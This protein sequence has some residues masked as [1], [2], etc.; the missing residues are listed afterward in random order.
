MPKFRFQ[1]DGVLRQRKLVEEQ[2]QREFGAVQAELVALQAQLREMDDSVQSTVGDLR[3]N[4]LVGR[5]DLSFLTAHRRYMLAMQRKAVALA[6][7]IAAAQVKVDEARAALL[8]AAMQ[9]KVIEKLRERRRA[10]WALE[11]E[12]KDMALLDEI[13]T[14]I[15]YRLGREAAADAADVPGEFASDGLLPSEGERA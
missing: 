2:R 10:A 14:Q 8:A 11:L 7:Q 15:G 9:R 3:E 4:R 6:Q 1:L 12:R 13:G 5:I